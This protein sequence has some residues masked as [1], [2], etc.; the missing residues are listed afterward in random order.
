MNVI[1]PNTHEVVFKVRG[2]L[3]LL[4]RKMFK[5]M[6]VICN[7]GGSGKNFARIRYTDFRVNN[8]DGV[9]RAQAIQAGIGGDDKGYIQIQP[10]YLQGKYSKGYLVTDLGR[11]EL[12]KVVKLGFR[13]AAIGE[14]A[15]DRKKTKQKAPDDRLRAIHRETLKDINLSNQFPSNGE[16]QD[17][18]DTLEF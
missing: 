7:R 11:K 17:P 4:E 14:G 13:E 18:L 3:S 16:L 8:N 10:G 15:D 12:K 9:T 2:S 5:C 6:A 1:S